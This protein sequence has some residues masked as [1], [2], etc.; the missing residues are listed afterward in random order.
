M[1]AA[2][3]PL[4]AALLIPVTVAR[5]QAKVAVEL[6]DVAVYVVE[7]LLQRFGAVA[8]LDMV[9]VGF[10]VTVTLNG[11]PAQPSTDGVITYT[12]LIGSS[13]LFTNASVIVAVDP[14]PVAGVIFVTAARLHAKVAVALLEVAV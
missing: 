10:I 4:P 7:V 1:I 3:D 12:T 8:L 13:K 5:F 9:A 6:L 2:V 14:L 11:V